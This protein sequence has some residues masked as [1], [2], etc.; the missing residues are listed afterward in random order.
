MKELLYITILKRNIEIIKL[1]L[2]KS[3][4]NVNY[5]NVVTYSHFYSEK[6]DSDSSYFSDEPDIDWNK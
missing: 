3:D 4:I 5:I 2:S 1:L 6:N